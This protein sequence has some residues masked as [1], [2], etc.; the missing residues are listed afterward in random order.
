MY[1]KDIL[2]LAA[3][4]ALITEPT[5]S[6]ILIPSEILTPETPQLLVEEPIKKTAEEKTLDS[7]KLRMQNPNEKDRAKLSAFK[8][9]REFVS[10]RISLTRY[11]GVS[12][13]P[14]RGQKGWLLDL[15]TKYLFSESIQSELSTYMTDDS[16]YLVLIFSEFLNHEWVITLPKECFKVLKK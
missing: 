7:I 9:C 15:N 11:I 16:I 5:S 2:K 6:G 1:I 8:L 4:K 14:K 10:H 13:F 3:D 12:P